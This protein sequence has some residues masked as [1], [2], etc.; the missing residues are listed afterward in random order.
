MHIHHEK[1][2]NNFHSK[3]RRLQVE[4]FFETLQ[5]DATDDQLYLDAWGLKRLFSLGIRR[6]NSELNFLEACLQGG[7]VF[8]EVCQCPHTCKN[9]FVSWLSC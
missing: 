2:I 4:L 3:P 7:D 6:M 5:V 1:H 8:S 9:M